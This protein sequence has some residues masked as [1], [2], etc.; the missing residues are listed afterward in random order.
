M[1]LKSGKRGGGRIV[2]DRLTEI[3]KRIEIKE[4][5]KR[6][7]NIIIKGAEVKEGKKREA[8]EQIL[9]IIG[10]KAEMGEI[11]KLE[12]EEGKDREMLVK[13]KDEVQKRGIM[14]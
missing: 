12:E 2:E 11:R 6:R 8:V 4:R 3:E 10:V 5:K 14:R 7:R 13:M 1:N 9:K